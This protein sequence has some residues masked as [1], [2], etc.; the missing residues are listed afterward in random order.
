M[1][2]LDL[3]LIMRFLLNL[4]PVVSLLILC[5]AA[6]LLSYIIIKYSRKKIA[7]D[8][9]K[10]NHEVGG[11]IFNAFVLIYAV[12]LAFVV[13]ATWSQYDESNRNIDLESIEITDLYHNSKAF[14]PP[15][16]QKINDALLNYINDVIYDEWPHLEKGEISE[17]ARASY[18]SI[19]RVY[20]SLTPQEIINVTA[21][22]ESMKHLNDLGERRRTRIFDSRNDLPDV[23]WA[24][25]LF[26][27]FVS[28]AYTCFFRTKKFAPQFLMTSALAALNV[29]VLYMLYML[30]NPFR[31][32]TMLGFTQFELTL[33]LIKSGM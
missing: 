16:K 6:V 14:P 3:F 18:N 17:K 9:V 29:L 31:G 7:Y 21:Y 5:S 28:V 33:Q 8:S 1:K 11:F 22:E 23:I 12:L 10:E 13:Y 30:D 26:G 24:A 2:F 25:L 4:H 20:T 19:W 15:V 32:Y 27:A